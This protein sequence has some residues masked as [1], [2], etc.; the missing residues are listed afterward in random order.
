[1]PRE[2]TGATGPAV[3]RRRRS[4]LDVAFHEAGHLAVAHHFGRTL[5]NASVDAETMDGGSQIAPPAARPRAHEELLIAMAGAAAECRRRGM[6]PR[7]CDGADLDRATAEAYRRPES[8][9]DDFGEV[10]ALLGRPP[11]WAMVERLARAL[12][13]HRTLSQ[14]DIQRLLPASPTAASMA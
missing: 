2:R 12:H 3:R 5:R 9:I 4:L 7:W 6:R 10:D 11:V 13:R 1:M 14:L 8:S